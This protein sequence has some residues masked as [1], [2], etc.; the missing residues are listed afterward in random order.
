MKK[1]AAI[2]HFILAVAMGASGIAF[3]QERRDD[4]DR[5][6]STPAQRGG[7]PDRRARPQRHQP[8]DVVND[9]RARHLSPPPRGYH[10]VQTGGGFAL[11]AIAT[12]VFL[13]LLL[14]P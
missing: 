14:H 9:W 5:A 7:P 13:Q 10:W 2:V 11:V 6:R 8:R 3:A 4:H 12:G 1:S